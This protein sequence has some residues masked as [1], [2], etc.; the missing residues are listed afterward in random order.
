MATTQLFDISKT[1]SLM[2]LDRHV[3]TWRAEGYGFRVHFLIIW[4]V[5][6]CHGLVRWQLH[7]VGP[8][9]F[10]SQVPF[11]KEPRLEVL[12]GKMR[13]KIQV[14]L[15]CVILNSNLLHSCRFCS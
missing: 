11:R 12:H 9:R 4:Y 1:I 6:G 8:R 14:L 2:D 13:T 7:C 3:G 15:L 5:I 10:N